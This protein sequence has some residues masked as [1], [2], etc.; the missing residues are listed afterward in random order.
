MAEKRIYG[1]DILRSV[2]ILTVVAEHSGYFLTKNKL[3]YG[4]FSWLLLDGV[5]IFFVLS[6]YLIGGIFIRVIN[7]PEHG[8]RQLFDFWIR[9][10]FRT[11]PNYYLMVL[12]LVPC[13]YAVGLG[14]TEHLW[15]YFFFL[16]NFHERHPNFFGEAWSLCVE[17]WFYLL[18]PLLAT[19]SISFLKV[20]K[21]YILLFWAFF[22][23]AFCTGLRVFRLIEHQYLN[24]VDYDLYIK[25]QVVTRLDSLM[26]GVLGAYMAYYHSR[27]WLKYRKYLFVAGL[28][29]IFAP[30]FNQ[31]V[32]GNGVFERYLSFT[33]SSLG[34]LLLIPQLSC[35]SSGKGFLFSFF[36]R[37]SKISY[38]MYI[39]HASFLMVVVFPFVS[40]M[41]DG[42]VANNILRA[43]FEYALFW[44]LTIGVSQF[45]YSYYEYP[46]MQLRNRIKSGD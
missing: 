9:R 22:F 45:L 46:F 11:L 27:A 5:T 13:W 35:L 15:K 4:Y 32:L 33:V 29:F 40:K 23:I 10:W 44:I 31:R 36:T 25:K 38:S 28:L 41:V 17:E 19:I 18:F 2:A 21:K 6:G 42:S 26:Y 12:V 39:I 1:L 3:S 14:V 20:D 7:K 43:F 8:F 37:I 34:T 24:P 30:E 16:Q